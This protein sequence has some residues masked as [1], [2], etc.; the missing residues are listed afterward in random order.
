MNRR[1]R[2][3]SIVVG[4]IDEHTRENVPNHDNRPSG[5]TRTRRPEDND[6][7][8]R[9]RELELLR[10]TLKDMS[11]KMHRAVSSA[12]EL[13]KVLEETQR[14]PFTARISNVRIRHISKI[15]LANYEGL[16]DPRPFLTSVSIAIG[17]AH[18]PKEERDAGSCQL[19]VE[20][21]SGAALTWFSR[22]EANSI[23][24]FHELTTSFLKNYGVFMEKGASNADLWTMAQTA[25]ESLRSFIGRFK[26]IITSV[27]TPDDAAI[28]ALRNA[29]WHESRFR[30]DLLLNQPATLADALHR[31]NRF[32]KIEEDKA[33]MAKRQG[34]SKVP[35]PKE[36]P[37]EEHHEPRQHYDAEYARDDKGKKGS[38]YYVGDSTARPDKPWNK[39]I[40]PADTKGDQS[41]CEFHKIPGHSTEECRQLQILLLAKFKKGDL[42]IEYDRRRAADKDGT[43]RR[44]DNA[45]RDKVDDRHRPEETNR[46]AERDHDANRREEPHKRNH[47][48]PR[49]VDN[50][51][52]SRRRI[53]MIMGG[54]TACRDS[55]RSIKSYRRHGEMQRE[56]IEKTTPPV[57]STEPITFSEADVGLPGTRN[58]PLVVELTIGKSTVTKILIDTGSSVNVIF[59]DVLLHIEIDLR[60]TQHKVQP[61]TGFD[62]D[63]IMTVGTITLPIYV[64]GTVS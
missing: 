28:A 37:K 41:Y 34:S 52:V 36:K 9:D 11:S 18:F 24:S 47:D 48:T 14:S 29:L 20:H 22:L 21:L 12:P 8:A 5:D 3:A 43:H 27:A 16:V 44:T 62:G 53:N 30:E 54:L 50:K 56:W 7:S 15:K 33:A 35:T 1:S 57:E 19:F 13:D 64:G 10:T 59:K 46:R 32:I 39:W 26:E 63:T 4:S 25:K 2:P 23:D 60:S 42:D 17:R 40:R 61:L 55:V 49:Q 6:V 45:D 38:T 58:D 51:P 31:A